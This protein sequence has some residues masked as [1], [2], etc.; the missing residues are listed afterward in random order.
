MA[1]PLLDYFINFII[2]INVNR[3]SMSSPPPLPPRQPLPL[4]TK[5]RN[6]TRRHNASCN[7][8]CIG[9]LPSL[10]TT[11]SMPVLVKAEV[12]MEGDGFLPSVSSYSSPDMHLLTFPRKTSQPSSGPKQT[13]SA[14]NLM[15]PE[16][17]WESQSTR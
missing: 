7:Q 12:H 9:G 3:T 11:P 16:I 8:T 17:S 2:F 6:P 15:G 1:W 13:S 4:P 10:Q 5:P 14:R